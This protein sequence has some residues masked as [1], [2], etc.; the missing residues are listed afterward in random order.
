MRV[1]PCLVN[2]ALLR[3]QRGGT[4]VSR[5]AIT[6]DGSK[7]QGP[8]APRPSRTRHVFWMS[9]AEGCGAPSTHARRDSQPAV[10]SWLRGSGSSGSASML[11]RRAPT[12]QTVLLPVEYTLGANLKIAQRKGPREV[13]YWND[14]GAKLDGTD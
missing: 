2:L 12:A 13:S 6:K 5:S 7:R 14:R 4:R 9:V 10:I 11:P 1:R 8:P 3:D